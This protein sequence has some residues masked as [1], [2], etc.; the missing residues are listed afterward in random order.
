MIFD[1]PEPVQDASAQGAWA[2][3]FHMSPRPLE[4]FR[5]I[6]E[7]D[8]QRPRGAL[9]ERVSGARAPLLTRGLPGPGSAPVDRRVDIAFQPKTEKL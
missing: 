6:A 7:H 9:V 5:G 4:G 2:A 8:R 3:G 1:V